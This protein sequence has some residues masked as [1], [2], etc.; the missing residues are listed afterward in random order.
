MCG[1][2]GTTD[3]SLESAPAVEDGSMSGTLKRTLTIR[4][5]SVGSH[6]LLG[7]GAWRGVSEKDF[8]S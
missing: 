2:E 6:A 5:E 7:W 4:R 1:V 3:L 8:G